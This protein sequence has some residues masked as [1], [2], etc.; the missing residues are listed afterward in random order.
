[1]TKSEPA[2]ASAAHTKERPEDKK[3]NLRIRLLTGKKE[4]PFNV[5]ADTAVAE[6]RNQAFKS[7]GISPSPG[8]RWIF[9]RENGDVLQDD[10]QTLRAAG[11]KDKDLLILGT[12]A[13]IL[14]AHAA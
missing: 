14:G 13:D 9:K 3:L 11:L 6:L 5:D 10:N 7:F 4:E 1:M 2:A 8:Q 12:E